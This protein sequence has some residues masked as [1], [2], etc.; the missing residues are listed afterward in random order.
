MSKGQLS[1]LITKILF[2]KKVDFIL[3]QNLILVYI[4][5]HLTAANQKC[6][7]IFF[8]SE[9]LLSWAWRINGLILK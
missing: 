1:Q 7:I 6:Q 3:L 2:Y 9:R 5:I 8:F 4:F